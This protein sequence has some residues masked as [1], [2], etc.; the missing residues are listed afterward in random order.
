MK[1]ANKEMKRQYGKV[2]INKIER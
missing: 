1:S 2:D